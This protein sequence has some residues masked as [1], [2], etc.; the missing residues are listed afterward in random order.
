[1][2]RGVL[3]IA[4]VVSIAGCNAH[5]E[6]RDMPTFRRRGYNAAFWWRHEAAYRTQAAIHVAHAYQHDALQLTPLTEARQIDRD[7]DAAYVRRLGQ[8]VRIGPEMA[9]S[10]VS[11]FADAENRALLER[12]FAGGVRVVA[13]TPRP[14]GTGPLS[15]KVVVF[16]G[17]LEGLTR[18][19]AK[20]LVEAQGARVAS[21]VSAKT[22]FLVQGAGGGGKAKQAAAL[23][24]RVL[25]EAEFRT[26]LAGGGAS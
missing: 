7:S 25:P 4:I 1:M 19:E 21:S 2:L 6:Q 3:S 9:E 8:D 20:R 26:L 23:G 12:L 22:D 24:V 18:A 11:W 10:V 15:G 13:A 5:F 17:T 16:T 14:G